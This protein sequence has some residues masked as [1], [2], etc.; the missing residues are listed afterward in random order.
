MHVQPH[1]SETD[2]ASS[3]HTVYRSVSIQLTLLKAACH[4][5]LTLN[6]ST[7]R[8]FLARGETPCVRCAQVIFAK[9]RNSANSKT[10]NTTAKIQPNPQKPQKQHTNP[11][12][13]NCRVS[14][15]YIMVKHGETRE[16]WQLATWASNSISRC[17]PCACGV[18]LCGPV[19][20]Q[21]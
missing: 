4:N 14:A 6:L 9:G 18:A 15:L 11:Q 17:Y 13:K 16:L 5:A 19:R 12:R 3:E 2:E 7:R 1:F 10:Q 20:A 21:A 8:F